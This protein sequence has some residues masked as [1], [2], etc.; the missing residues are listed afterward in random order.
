M[1]FFTQLFPLLLVSCSGAGLDSLLNSVQDGSHLIKFE[2]RVLSFGNSQRSPAF[3]DKEVEIQNSSQT[4]VYIKSFATTHS[5]FSVLSHNCPQK[6]LPLDSQSKCKIF[7]RFSPALDGDSSAVLSV[8]FLGSL[9]AKKVFN[10]DLGL[11]GRSTSDGVGNQGL[12]FSPQPYDFGE[13][14]P[15]PTTQQR[16]FDLQNITNTPLY[17]SGFSSNTPLFSIGNHTCPLAPLPIAA[18]A[19]CSLAVIY[20]ALTSGRHI[21]SV[22]ATYGTTDLNAGDLLSSLALSGSS[23]PTSPGTTALTFSPEYYDFGDRALNSLSEYSFTIT[24][25][26]SATIYVDG[27]SLAAGDNDFSVLSTNCPTGLNPYPAGATCSATIRF[28]P[29]SQ[30]AKSASIQVRYGPTHSQKNDFKCTFFCCRA[31]FSSSHQHKCT[32]I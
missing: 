18:G 9:E 25:S 3:V 12:K 23:T 5:D 10:S 29:S 8:N 24:N 30:T 1:R 28:V 32:R 16:T 22:S 15:S 19:T 26:S 7:L 13:V 20:E 21:G 17:L 4:S 14:P 2:P 11:S 27:I 6:P 31:L